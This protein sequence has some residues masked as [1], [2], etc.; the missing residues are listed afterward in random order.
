MKK[1]LTILLFLIISF[2]LCAQ[3]DL[4]TEDLKL[5][6]DH[7]LRI[8]SIYG[9]K[10]YLADTENEYLLTIKSGVEILNPQKTKWKNNEV[11]V[12]FGKGISISLL[13]YQMNDY[14]KGTSK[15]PLL[16]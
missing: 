13:C 6:L 15:N 4:K 2:S 7:Q 9:A 14:I 11:E 8:T 12:D 16:I 5:S 3:K 1:T 10:E